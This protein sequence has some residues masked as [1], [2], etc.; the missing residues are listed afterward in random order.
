MT[1]TET[2]KL[3]RKLSEER[4]PPTAA[5]AEPRQVI[6]NLERW[7]NST[8]LQPPQP[9]DAQNGVSPAA[10]PDASP[11]DNVPRQ[12]NRRPAR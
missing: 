11:P 6:E 7:A 12:T 2:L 3:P 9:A 5:A 4:K 8:G 10:P 1:M